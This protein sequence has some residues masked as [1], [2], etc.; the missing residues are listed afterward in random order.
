MDEQTKILLQ[1]FIDKVWSEYSSQLYSDLYRT[2][3]PSTYVEG[4][5]NPKGNFELALDT[6]GEAIQKGKSYGLLPGGQDWEVPFSKSVK[7]PNLG[8]APSLGILEGDDNYLGTRTTWLIA[9]LLWDRLYDIVEE[10]RCYCGENG[11]DPDCKGK[12]MG[13]FP[14]LYE[15][16]NKLH[17]YMVKLNKSEAPLDIMLNRSDTLNKIQLSPERDYIPTEHPHSGD[18]FIQGQ[19]L[20]LND[21]MDENIDKFLSRRLSV[22]RENIYNLSDGELFS[23]SEQHQLENQICELFNIHKHEASEQLFKWSI[24]DIISETKMSGIDL[25]KKQSEYDEEYL[26]ILSRFP[27]ELQREIIDERPKGD[28]LDIDEL[29]GWELNSPNPIEVSLSDL[30]KKESTKGSVSRT[31]QEVVDIINQNWNTSI[32]LAKKL[33]DSNPERYMKD[34]EQ[35][36]GSTA[37]PSIMVNGDVI[38]GVGRMVAA[39]IRPDKIIKVWDI[40]DSKT[41]TEEMNYNSFDLNVLGTELQP[42]STQPITGFYRDGY[43]KT[44]EGDSGTHTVCAKVDSEFLEFSKSKGNDLIT[45][46]NSFPGLK[47]G[48]KWCLCA[49]RWDQA[50]KAGLAPEVDYNSTNIRTVDVIGDIVK[51]KLNENESPELNPELEEG[52]KIIVVSKKTITKRE[53]DY[54][55][56]QEP[57]LY[58]RYKVVEKRYSGHKS[59]YPYHYFLLP[60]TPKYSHIKLGD[61][62]DM[63]TEDHKDVKALYPWISDWIRAKDKKKQELN[64]DLEEG[65]YV[66]IISVDGQ[67]ANMPE[68]WEVYKV[69]SVNQDGATHRMYYGLY[70]TDQT[71][72]KLL[73]SMLAGGGKQRE[74]YLY[75]GDEWIKADPPSQLNE[76]VDSELNPEL[77]VGDLIRVLEI[78][79]KRDFAPEKWKPYE[80]TKLFWGGAGGI[81]DGSREEVLYYQVMTP[82][83]KVPFSDPTEPP[84]IRNIFTLRPTYDTWQ[85]IDEPKEISY[86]DKLEGMELEYDPEQANTGGVREFSWVDEETGTSTDTLLFDIDY[87]RTAPIFTY[88]GDSDEP[89]ENELVKFD[90]ILKGDKS[91]LFNDWFDLDD[92]E[93]RKKLIDYFNLGTRKSVLLNYFYD[94]YLKLYGIKKEYLRLEN[95]LIPDSDG[96]VRNVSGGQQLS[97]DILDTFKVISDLNK[98]IVTN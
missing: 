55:L 17:D 51:T 26:E 38:W 57:K 83:E 28:H 12:C 7:P 98:G 20:G 65:D 79:Q 27:Q 80:V 33:Y 22:I 15:D 41:L 69:N 90:L 14:Y 39:L 78:G 53:R 73:S 11:I 95:V 46:S 43:C 29:K 4:G 52:D 9:V 93:T 82:G 96:V 97:E 10:F 32:K 72:D 23:E 62:T 74:L 21:R 40:K 47:P 2:Y 64:P 71:D 59:K 76:E 25:K 91:G 87:I 45:P 92:R 75:F 16:Y 3:H 61:S 89:E 86:L 13:E 63:S 42:C 67:H 85:K 18:V 77:E 35:F 34:A 24:K 56:D 70:P 31:N 88:G 54:F 81:D 50:R 44:G 68:K 30:I 60:D 58:E 48:D 1:K 36:D 5:T 37:P 66:K 49:N 94:N 8:Y 6:I 19:L 84:N